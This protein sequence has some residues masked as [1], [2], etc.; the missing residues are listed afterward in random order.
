MW[1]GYNFDANIK[2][3]FRKICKSQTVAET[4]VIHY[5]NKTEI[6]YI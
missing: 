1:K 5:Y 6:T 3:I 4:L 2:K